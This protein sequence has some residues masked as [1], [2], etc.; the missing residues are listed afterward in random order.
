LLSQINAL[1]ALNPG[2]LSMGNALNDQF[3]PGQAVLDGVKAPYAGWAQQMT[4]CAPTVAQALLPFPQ[5]CGNIY[6]QNESDGNS[7][8]HALQLSAERRF[9]HGLYFLAAYTFSKTLTD[10]D[11]SQS[12]QGPTYAISPFQQNREKALSNQDTPNA[13]TISS[14]YDLPIGNGKWLLNSSGTV[15]NFFLSGWQIN[16]IFH[17]NSG[18]PIA[19]RSSYCNIPSQFA[20]ACIPTVLQG[21]NPYAQSRGSFNPSEPLFDV[22]SFTSI[23]TFNFNFGDGPRVSNLRGF[24]YTNMD[25]GIIK[26][27]AI[28]ERFRIQIRGEAFNVFNFHSFLNNFVSDIQNPGFGTWN[29]SATA[30]RNLQL[31]GKIT[32]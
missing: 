9:S 5:Y 13:I 24:G 21:A 26:N 18:Q 1:N 28:K 20:A 11:Y 32:F 15:K 27:F 17:A 22:N 16:G 19:F 30:P 12:S 6:G 25:F 31:G 23:D 10:A 3:A 29:G 2:L 14:T 8:Y 4:G 7:T